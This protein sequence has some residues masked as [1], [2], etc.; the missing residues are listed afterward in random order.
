MRAL[1]HCDPSRRNNGSAAALC[2]A[3]A[4]AALLRQDSASHARLSHRRLLLKRTRLAQPVPCAG[5]FVAYRMPLKEDPHIPSLVRI[6]GIASADGT[7]PDATIVWKASWARAP[8]MSSGARVEVQPG[9]G[10]CACMWLIFPAAAGPHSANLQASTLLARLQGEKVPFSLAK[11]PAPLLVFWLQ[12]I[13]SDE[14]GSD[15]AVVKGDTMQFLH[16]GALC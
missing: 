6:V 13:E 9:V 16:F 15:E 11:T 5:A 4:Q 10:S 7:G 8:R 3:A 1:L 14:A 2:A 12:G